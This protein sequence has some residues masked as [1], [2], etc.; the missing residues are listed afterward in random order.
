MVIF[1]YDAACCY[2]LSQTCAVEAAITFDRGQVWRLWGSEYLYRRDPEFAQETTRHDPSTVLVS[3]SLTDWPIVPLEATSFD[4]NWRARAINSL[5]ACEELC[6]LCPKKSNSSR[7]R[8][9]ASIL[10]RRITSLVWF[11]EWNFPLTAAGSAAR[12]CERLWGALSTKLSFFFVRTARRLAALSRGTLLLSQWNPW[13]V[14][15]FE[16][17]WT[18]S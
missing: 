14:A 17:S 3:T 13:G 15:I 4:L 9:L 10:S 8:A 6:E 16:V 5:P 18:C 12:I 2:C 11:V 7:V 1:C